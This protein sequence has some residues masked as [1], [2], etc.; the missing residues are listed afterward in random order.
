MEADPPMVYE[1]TA[2]CLLFFHS[3]SVPFQV[4]LDLLI[5]AISAN[6]AKVSQSIIGEVEN[7]G[8][9][10]MCPHEVVCH[11]CDEA[12]VVLAHAID[13]VLLHDLIELLALIEYEVD[14][15]HFLFTL[16]IW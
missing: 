14:R 12:L 16:F 13:D 15:F 7:I 11:D 6:D 8:F 9:S 4:V 5:D 1:S 2:L 3:I 10:G